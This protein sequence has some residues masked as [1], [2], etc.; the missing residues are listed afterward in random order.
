MHG[1]L[2]EWR[3]EKI[4][5]KFG[6]KRRESLECKRWGGD[7]DKDKIKIRKWDVRKGWRER[8]SFVSA[9]TI[10]VW[11]AVS[12]KEEKEAEEGNKLL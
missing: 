2:R 10:E 12:L 8:K 6:C 5:E 11:Q 7:L 4:L 9:K 1:K 3:P